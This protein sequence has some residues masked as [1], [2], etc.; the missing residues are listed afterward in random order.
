M[1]IAYVSYEHPLG[2][3]GGGIGT[4]MGQ[5]S[6]LM[7]NRGHSV[8]VFCGTLNNKPSTVD[9][10]GYVLHLIPAANNT[11]FRTRVVNVFAKSHALH[12]FD[13]MESAEYGAD[14]LEVKKA[15]PTLPLTLKLHTPAFLVSKLNNHKNGVFDKLRFVIGGLIRL[16][17]VKFYWTYDQ[18]NDPEY[19]LFN[20]AESVSSPSHS[21]A[22]IVNNKWGNS[23]KISIIPYPFINNE[24]GL[25]PLPDKVVS[26]LVVTFIGKVER[27]KG[28]LDLMKAI[29]LVLTEAPEVK[30]WFVGSPSLSPDK[31]L[32]MIAY[33]KNKLSRFGNS[34]EF[35]GFKPYNEIPSIIAASDI[36]IFPSLWENFPNVCLEAMLAGKPVIGTNNGG[37]ADMIQDHINGLLIPPKSPKAIANAILELYNN[38]RL[39]THLGEAARKTVTERYSGEVIGKLV[40]NFYLQ[41][42]PAG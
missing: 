6:A 42:I 31:R 7:A 10:K 32:N 18:K 5:I 20:L 33:L 39:V 15:F 13:I 17:K 12:P 27:R 23:K 11:E 28:V 22:K 41:T 25:N 1:R 34:L 26:G 2:I 19:Q 30:F 8:E 29:P 14:G 40:E 16:Q 4:Y 9:C 36:C 3:A 35:L 24:I 38:A 21:L 37:M